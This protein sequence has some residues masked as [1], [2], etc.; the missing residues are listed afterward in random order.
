MNVKKIYICLYVVFVNI[1]QGDWSEIGVGG[2]GLRV[3][4]G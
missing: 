3:L 2:L 4:S 1:F